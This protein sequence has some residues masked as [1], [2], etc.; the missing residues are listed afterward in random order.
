M[1]EQP[2]FFCQYTGTFAR[3]HVGVFF[4]PH[5]K[6]TTMP[7]GKRTADGPDS[8]ERSRESRKKKKMLNDALSVFAA[9]NPGE[10]AVGSDGAL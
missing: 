9:A 8:S 3:T 1:G 10:G 4:C 2:P 6:I 7:R 5:D